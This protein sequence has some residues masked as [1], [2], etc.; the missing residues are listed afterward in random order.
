MT[1]TSRSARE[2]KAWACLTANALV[3]PGLGSIGAGRFVE[4]TLQA[5]AS[6]A[7]FALTMSWALPFI[8]RAATELTLPE[9]LGP[10]GYGL[11]GLLLFAAAWVWGLV[12]GVRLLRE[13]KNARAHLRH[14]FP[15]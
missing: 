15:S 12:T 1:R 10:I 4:G 13:A 11:G 5:I 6:V 2:I 3:L 8:G 9:E 7:G 14:Q